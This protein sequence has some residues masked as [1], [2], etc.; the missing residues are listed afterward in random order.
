MPAASGTPQRLN[1][2]KFHHDKPGCSAC[3]SSGHHQQQQGGCMPTRQ[4]HLQRR[5]RDAG[6]VALYGPP[7][8][9]HFPALVVQA[10]GR[11]HVLLRLCT[12]QESRCR[13]CRNRPGQRS[14]ILLLRQGSSSRGR[15]QGKLLHIHRP[16]HQ[17]Q[18]V[19]RL[20]APRSCPRLSAGVQGRGT[21]VE[22]F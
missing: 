22:S 17:L 18:K 14:C 3:S 13:R 16:Q 21:V 2:C 4:V 11:R 15:W 8:L 9:V 20:C 7:K 19:C 10:Q 6:C 5:G 12:R 1:D